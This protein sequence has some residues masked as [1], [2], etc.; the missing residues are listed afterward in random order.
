MRGS[1]L[2]LRGHHLQRQPFLRPGRETLHATLRLAADEVDAIRAEVDRA[3]RAEPTFTVE[4]SNAAG[5]VHAMCEKLLSV[6]RRKGTTS[7]EEA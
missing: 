7:M 5:Q 1:P 2:Q 4:L 6:R 3:G